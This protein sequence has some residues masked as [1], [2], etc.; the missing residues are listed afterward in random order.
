MVVEPDI[1]LPSVQ[2]PWVCLLFTFLFSLQ[3]A[4]VGRVSQADSEHL[5]EKW[6]GLKY[7]VSSHLVVL[8]IKSCRSR[9]VMA[10]AFNQQH[11]GDRGRPL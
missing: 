9:K 6:P 1:F 8:R 11:S 10:H 5:C 7:T 3:K 2:C 4:A